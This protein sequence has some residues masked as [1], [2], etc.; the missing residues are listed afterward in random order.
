V[1][2]DCVSLYRLAIGGSS[3]VCA[4][5]MRGRVFRI[6]PVQPHAE[7]AAWNRDHIRRSRL[8]RPFDGR[9][10]ASVAHGLLAS[11]EF[12]QSRHRVS[13]VRPA[14]N[15]KCVKPRSLCG[16]SRAI[17]SVF[18][19]NHSSSWR[20]LNRSNNQQLAPRLW[21]PSHAKIKSKCDGGNKRQIRCHRRRG[22]L[23]SSLRQDRL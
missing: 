16:A 13:A 10:N 21:S 17:L 22:R 5:A 15:D 2:A 11:S 8:L 9:N 3:M 14:E 1:A 4:D 12:S 23:D 7:P 18:D 19:G 20:A 6:M